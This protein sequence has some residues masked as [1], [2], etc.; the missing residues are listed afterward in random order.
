MPAMP[1]VADT[2]RNATSTNFF[3]LLSNPAHDIKCF[4]SQRTEGAST[5]YQAELF[6][7]PQA[8]NHRYE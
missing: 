4:L 5:A 8:H 7:K 3:A 2:R 1:S 6:T